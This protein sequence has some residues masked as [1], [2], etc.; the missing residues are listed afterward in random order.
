MEEEVKKLDHYMFEFNADVSDDFRTEQLQKLSKYDDY[1]EDYN[2]TDWFGKI[3]HDIFEDREVNNYDIALYTY[4]VSRAH[5]RTRQ[6]DVILNNVS[7]ETIVA[8]F[9]IDGRNKK[10]IKQSFQR[11]EIK[12]Y[13]K[14]QNSFEFKG[15]QFM[16]VKISDISDNFFK[17]YKYAIDRIIY[18]SHNIHVIAR[19]SAYTSI[20]SFIYEGKSNSR[21]AYALTD[22]IITNSRLKR[23]NCLDELDWLVD[24][25]VLACFNCVR[26]SRQGGRKKYY[27]DIGDH[28]QLK[29]FIA[30]QFRDNKL[31]NVV[32]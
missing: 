10:K 21:V 32:N 5:V 26:K 14:L 23:T 8:E 29:W 17:V 30:S 9:D 2:H 4:L 28:T 13:I 18:L 3:P 25:R 22:H 16:S 27:S 20:R 31:R 1:K 24:N 11:L 7:A 19:L 15:A 6:G 12:G